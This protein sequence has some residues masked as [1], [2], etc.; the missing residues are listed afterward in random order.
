MTKREKIA[1]NGFW[2]HFHKVKVILTK[3]MEVKGS[4]L[5]VRI[6]TA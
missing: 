3:L 2:R 1:K 4:D 6:A 5:Q